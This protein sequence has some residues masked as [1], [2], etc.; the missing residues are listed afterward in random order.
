MA[1]RFT[2][3]EIWGEDWFLA[4]PIEYKLFWYYMLA[5][6]DHGGLFK[7][8]LKSF[9]G[10]NEVKVTTTNAL[11]YFNEGKERIRVINSSVWYVEDFFVFQYG[12]TFNTNNRLHA[13]I[14]KLYEKLGIELTSIRGVLDLID[15]V[16]EKEKDK[17]RG[18]STK[19]E[20]NGSAKQFINVKTQGE[21]I[22]AAR[23]PNGLPRLDEYGKDNNQEPTGR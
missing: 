11:K 12:T 1:K 3:T 4:M 5:N 7:V 14:Q 18:Y 22:L 20:K 10:L 17:E 13:S 9:C 16:K 19:N 23:Y 2:A 6:C 15:G 21:D 8:N